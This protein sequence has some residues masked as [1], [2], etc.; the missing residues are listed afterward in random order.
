LN[1][2]YDDW[3]YGAG[4]IVE[5]NC[6]GYCWNGWLNW[7]GYDC[8]GGALYCGVGGGGALKCEDGV[9]GSNHDWLD[10][11]NCDDGG[12]CGCDGYELFWYVGYSLFPY[13]PFENP[14]LLLNLIILMK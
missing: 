10:M 5:L 13:I 7:E 6:E 8:G 2:L 12:G 4:G 3:L 14:M 1:W 9:G 11:V